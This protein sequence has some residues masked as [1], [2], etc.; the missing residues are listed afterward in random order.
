[1]YEVYCNGFLL[2]SNT[3]ENLKLINPKASL[4]DNKTGSFTFTIYPNHPYYD[5]IHK[6]TSIITVYQDDY[7]LFRGRVLNDELG[8][9]NEKSITCEGE[10]AFFLDSV[11]RPYD[12]SGSISG[13]LS[14]L[15]DNHNAQVESYKQ[16]TLGKVTVTD[17]NNTIIR[18]D[19]NCNKTWNVIEKKLIEL[20]GGHIIVRHE[21][22]VNYIDYLSDYTTISNQTIEFSKNLLDMKRKRKG[23]S[24]ITALIPYGAKLKDESGEETDTRLDITSV[25]GGVDYIY[26]ADAVAEHGWIFDTKTWDDVTVASNLLTKAN[27]HLASLVSIIDTLDITAADLAGTGQQVSSFHL[28][29]YVRVTS[30]PHGID[31]TFRVTKLSIDLMKPASNKLTLGGIVQSLTQGMTQIVIP[32]DG[33]DGK[34]GKGI[35]STVVTYQA[36][37]SGTSVPTGTWQST[38][39]SVA[40]NQ[41][42]WTRI[43]ITYSDS[44]TTT[45]Y[46]VGKMGASGADGSMI[47]TTTTAPKSPN[48]TFTIS[49]LSGVSGQTPKV[50]DIIIYAYYRYTITSVASTTV[51]AGSRVS[52]RGATGAA[53]KD[54]AIQ[55]DTP[56]TD[57]SYLWLDTSVNPPLMK[58]YAPEYELLV[59]EPS[60]WGSNY[61]SYFT[62]NSSSGTYSAVTG[63]TAP[64]FEV[65]KYYKYVEW[66]TVNDTTQAFYLMEKNVSSEIA[67]SET[68]IMSKVS[69][70]YYLKDETDSLI[71]S[72][73]TTVQQNKNSVDILFN[74]YSADLQALANGTDAEFEEIKKYIRFIDGKIL[75]GQVGNALELK[76][77]H[78]RISFLQSNAEVAYFSNNK[79]FVTDG[80]YTNS[81]RLGQFAFLPRSNGNLSFKKI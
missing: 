12:Y 5:M 30:N 51:L 80:E 55:S 50:G 9:R 33:K 10:L 3:I 72:V 24:I 27:A 41:Y 1:M 36:S 20:L 58:R 40:E 7:V 70:E 32:K 61:T 13:F 75:L 63:D 68:N 62:Y 37:T 66:V 59:A 47:W 6:L 67:K 2:H 73:S 77:S 43:L 29:T 23:E 46:S 71:S 42:L 19:I 28:G 48:Y 74:Q 38:I 49:N 14:Q 69:E 17:P 26:D 16:F 52:I 79:L 34:D 60:D 81:L 8:F 57:T 22:G 25:N 45:S 15:I 4:E 18:S 39:P 64:A 76:I 65:D 44:T 31:Q 53:G 78:D 54:A 11:Y 21:N 35:K 56:P